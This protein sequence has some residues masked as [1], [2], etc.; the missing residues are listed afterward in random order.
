MNLD[1]VND[2]G[3]ETIISVDEVLAYETAVELPL[4]AS[5]AVRSWQLRPGDIFTVVDR[6]GDYWRARL[7]DGP[8]QTGRAVPFEQLSQPTESRV[9]ISLYQALP[10][11][12]RFEL[13]LQK[14][15]ELGVARI[16]P[17]LTG[18]SSTRQARDAG[19]KKSH[20][21]PDV[22]LKAARQCRRA[23]IPELTAVSGWQDALRAAA[24]CE[25]KM[26]LYEG[27]AAWTMNEMLARQKPASV[28]LFIGPEGGFTDQEVAEAREQGIVPVCLGP[29]MLRTET[30]A[31][32]AVTAVQFA[33]GDFSSGNG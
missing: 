10:D 8:G 1:C 9:S 29:R 6:Q 22:L 13:V 31:I 15:T 5:A 4:S 11:K 19:Q 23:M 24:G 16:S 25:V 12:E 28:A 3:P 18:K 20:R 14:A 32:A 17:I 30:A 27:R 2:G 21:W 7:A 33:V 26:L